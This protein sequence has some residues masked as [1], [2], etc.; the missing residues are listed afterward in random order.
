MFVLGVVEIESEGLVL[1]NLIL[2]SHLQAS[3]VLNCDSYPARPGRDDQM[4]N[5][6]VE[7]QSAERTK[8]KLALPNYMSIVDEPGPYRSYSYSTHSWYCQVLWLSLSHP[9]C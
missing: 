8:V 9:E 2:Y 3:A 7:R 1:H 6:T 5:A 4:L